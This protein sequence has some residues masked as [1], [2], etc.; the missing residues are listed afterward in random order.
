MI[1]VTFKFYQ[2]DTDEFVIVRNVPS[3]PHVGDGVSFEGDF[4]NSYEVAFVHH[5]L[6]K[7]GGTTITARL[8]RI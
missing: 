3:V 2:S 4:A 8:R 1:P 6:M 7:D 5:T